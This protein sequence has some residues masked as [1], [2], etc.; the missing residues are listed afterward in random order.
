MTVLIVDDSPII[1]TKLVELLEEVRTIKT[2]KSSNSY[3]QAVESIDGHTPDVVL[4]DI[5]LP[6]KSGIQLLR[7]VKNKLPLTIVIMVTNQNSTYYKN[8]CIDLGAE[9]FLDKSRDFET[10]PFILSSLS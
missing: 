4:L 3:I 5:N 1:I 10:L 2:I 9:H 8:L 6:D 7:Y